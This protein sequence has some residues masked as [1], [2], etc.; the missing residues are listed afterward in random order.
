MKSQRI[1]A[2][3]VIEVMEEEGLIP[4][5]WAYLVESDRLQWFIAPPGFYSPLDEPMFKSDWLTTPETLVE[6]LMLGVATVVEGLPLVEDYIRR[7]ARSDHGEVVDLGRL[8]KAD[9]SE[10]N[11]LNRAA[12]H[13][14]NLVVTV[15]SGSALTGQTQ[16]FGWYRVA[17]EICTSQH[18]QSVA[19]VRAKS[20]HASDR[21][22]PISIGLN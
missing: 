20:L 3:V 6:D 7:V 18:T 5:N 13:E 12:R 1:T 10:V 4:R 14:V 16:K 17:V 11:R 19:G 15:L 21:P 22:P 8:S 2:Y 9:R